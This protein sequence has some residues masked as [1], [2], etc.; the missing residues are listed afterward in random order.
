VSLCILSNV[1]I[2]VGLG[3]RVVN[4]MCYEDEDEVVHVAGTKLL[5]RN[6]DSFALGPLYG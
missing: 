5:E 1:C 6:F 4:S 3:R 2:G